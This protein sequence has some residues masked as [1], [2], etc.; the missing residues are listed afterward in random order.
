MA[1]EF[2]VHLPLTAVV[3]FGV[4]CGLL[5]QTPQFDVVSIKPNSTGSSSSSMNSRTGGLFVATNVT[6][7][8]LITTAYDLRPSQ[9]V[10][11]PS[12]LDAERFDVN[13]RAAASVPDSAFPTM[14]QAML[15]DRF[16][17]GVHRETREL[18]VY[19]LVQ[20]TAGQ[21]GPKLKAA[22]SECAQEPVPGLLNPCGS[23]MSTSLLNGNGVMTCRRMPM[24]ALAR[25]LSGQVDRIV[26]DRTGLTGNFDCELKFTPEDRGPSDTRNADAPSVFTAVQ[27]QL[28]LKLDA[29]RGPVGVLVIDRLERP[30]EN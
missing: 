1:A 7:R 18:P 28:G 14:I 17:L 2:R 19:A 27:E 29:T 24:E 13:A 25:S 26:I 5:A 12:W 20:R 11:G 9:V 16:Q 23:G 21:T 15:V 3:V 22:S 6:V 8:S 10:G 30:T 4:A